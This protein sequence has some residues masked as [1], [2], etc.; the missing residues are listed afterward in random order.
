MTVYPCPDNPIPMAHDPV[1]VVLVSVRA[2]RPSSLRCP[3]LL[4]FPFHDV[5]RR[6]K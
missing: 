3:N 1:C 2:S 6:K 5:R 4:V